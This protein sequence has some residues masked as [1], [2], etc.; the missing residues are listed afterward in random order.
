MIAVFG[1]YGL[2]PMV[3]TIDATHEGPPPSLR[4]AWSEFAAL[5]VMN[6]TCGSVMVAHHAERERT[7]GT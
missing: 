4:P 2:L 6:V 3:L 1:Q 7:R 5:G